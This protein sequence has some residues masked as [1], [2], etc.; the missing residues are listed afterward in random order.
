MHFNNMVIDT[1]KALINSGYLKI[2]DLDVLSKNP[3]KDLEEEFF[4]I[5]GDDPDLESIDQFIEKNKNNIDYDKALMAIF[6]FLTE[7]DS[8]SA[9]LQEKEKDE[10][11]AFTKA[12]IKNLKNEKMVILQK[13]QSSSMA[14]F[15]S[16]KLLHEPSKLEDKKIG[17]MLLR[18]YYLNHTSKFMQPMDF[19]ACNK[20]ED[21]NILQYLTKV[22]TR[23]FESMPGDTAIQKMQQ[24]N[25][26]A[27]HNTQK[28]F[29]Y[30]LSSYI[31]VDKLLLTQ[32]YRIKEYLE[33][34][35]DEDL[36]LNKEFLKKV[37]EKM[38][39]EDKNFSVKIMD[40]KKKKE[41]TKYS[42]FDLQADLKKFVNGKYIGRNY[43]EQTLEGIKNEE[44]NINQIEEELKIFPREA[45]MQIAQTSDENFLKIEGL[46]NLS[47]EEIL[48]AIKNMEDISPK[49]ISKLYN[50]GKFEDIKQLYKEGIITL[51]AIKQ[52]RENNSEKVQDEVNEKELV[53]LYIN[54]NRK[55]S[56]T[57]EKQ[58][59][60]QYMILYKMIKVR[61]NKDEEKLKE[62]AN[63]IIMEF[64]DSF[65]ETIL[66]DLYK[67]ELLPFETVLE[68][69]N[70]ETIHDIL[71]SGF[72]RPKEVKEALLNGNLQK[73][74]L[75]NILQDKKL[76]YGRKMNILLDLFSD[77][78]E[79]DINL[80]NEYS[81]YI[82]VYETSQN[83]T[84]EGSKKQNSTTKTKSRKFATEPYARIAFLKSLDEDVSIEHKENGFE[85]VKLPNLKNGLVVIEKI[86]TKNGKPV[87]G[88]ATY[89]L[90]DEQYEQ[91]SMKEVNRELLAELREANKA[92]T[93][94]HTKNSWTKQLLELA[95]LRKYRGK[96]IN[97]GNSTKYTREHLEKIDKAEE[98]VINSREEI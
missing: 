77:I 88:T 89:V 56:T 16:K 41:E 8:L 96:I 47:Q 26:Y 71:K 78:S 32:A 1:L 11:R 36:E 61:G 55:E 7:T 76:D 84:G 46:F 31:N 68:W 54:A 12:K 80:F 81:R 25:F 83:P 33:N 39:K 94:G 43:I 93:I 24:E 95:E 49:T 92:I 13:P 5:Y 38:A 23:F 58:E 2:I 35:G 79:E 64:G 91:Y 20:M 85:I 3:E 53:E 50:D 73:D 51:E 97:K 90:D 65:N 10:L 52:I 37:Y 48:S 40:Y 86:L 30:Q 44:I 18:D 60:N 45:I 29:V 34:G 75:I 82:D 98:L 4:S 28:A 62:S 87:Y 70:T 17:D 6:Y 59:F 27:F 19:E 67:Q 69:A 21:K 22:Y 9:L 57:E 72:M 66:E 74:I 42:R 63:K 15:T 14:L